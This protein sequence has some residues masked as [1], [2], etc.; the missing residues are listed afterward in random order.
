[1]SLNTARSLDRLLGAVARGRVHRDPNGA[2]WHAPRSEPGLTHGQANFKARVKEGVTRAANAG[3][4]SVPD[5]AGLVTLTELGQARLAD[6]EAAQ[7]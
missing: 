2:I 1:V 7:R 6:A 4:V 3:L 5:D